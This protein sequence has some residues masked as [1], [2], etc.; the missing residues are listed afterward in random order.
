MERSGKS[1]IIA[2]DGPAGSGKSTVSKRLAEKLELL[3]IDTGAM[4][5][6]LTLKAINGGMDLDD[7]DSL[8]AMARF[9]AIDL[10]DENGSKKVFL[11]GKDVS[12][13][14]RTPEL[15]SKVRFIARVPGVRH[16]MVKLQRSIGERQGAVLEGRDIGTVVFPDADYKFYLDA[17]PGERAKRRY[18]ELLGSG[19]KVKLEEILKDV[20][21]RDESDMKR[22]VGALKK[23]KDSVVVDTTSLSIDEVVE[24]LFSHISEKK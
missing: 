1:L 6:A 15:T 18:K 20:I 23:A 7:G 22:A 10:K 4:Y 14:I 9:T 11:D 12:L 5:R 17:D 21:E 19:R 8:T 13:A 24:K 16:E 2:I 3:Y